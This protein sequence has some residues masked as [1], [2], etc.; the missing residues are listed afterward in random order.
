MKRRLALVLLSAVMV[1]ALAF[2][3]AACG[4]KPARNSEFEEYEKIVTTV[5]ENTVGKLGER[6]QAETQT[7]AAK[8]L[9]SR[10]FSAED[11]DEL[12]VYLNGFTDKEA[13][14]NSSFYRDV[15]EQT[16]YLP[17][18]GGDIIREYHGASNFYGVTICAPF[19]GQYFKTVSEGTRKITYAL[20]DSPQTNNAYIYMEI[21]F[22][23]ES[24]FAFRA[25]QTDKTGTETLFLYGNDDLQFLA[26]SHGG[27]DGSDYVL[28][29]NPNGTGFRILDG[30][31]IEYCHE[32][33]AEQFSLVDR[34]VL[35]GM[36]DEEYYAVAEDEWN[37][38]NLKYFP[39]SGMTVDEGPEWVIENGIVSAY[40]WEHKNMTELTLPADAEAVFFQLHIPHTVKKL[41]FPANI[42]SIK[43]PED[44]LEYLET[45][46]APEDSEPQPGEPESATVYVDCPAKYFQIFLNGEESRLEEISVEDGCDIFKVENNCL[47]GAD[48]T[49][50]YVPENENI[51]SLSFASTDY[52]RL[53][54]GTSCNLQNLK[55][56]EIDFEGDEQP[57]FDDFYFEL[58]GISSLESVTLNNIGTRNFSVTVGNV[59]EDRSKSIKELYLGGTGDAS[60]NISFC[61]SLQNVVIGDGITDYEFCAVSDSDVE[62]SLSKDVQTGH[63]SD[64]DTGSKDDPAYTETHY[65][66]LLP[67]SKI[68]FEHLKK[69]TVLERDFS[70]YVYAEHY[71][72]YDKT[73]F[74]HH[75]A[76]CTVVFQ[77]LSAAEQDEADR[78]DSFKDISFITEEYSE[79]GEPYAAI[80]GYWGEENVIKVPET[81]LGYPVYRFELRNTS[82]QTDLPEPTV[83]GVTELHLPA[84]LKDFSVYN[85]SYNGEP[86]YALEK[87]VYGGTKEEFLRIINDQ[88]YRELY[89]LLEFTEEIICNGEILTPPQQP[90][91]E[92][93][94]F[95]GEN[96]NT[97]QIDLDWSD[98]DAKSTIKAVQARLIYNGSEYISHAFDQ[99]AFSCGLQFGGEVPEGEEKDFASVNFETALRDS[100]SSRKEICNLRVYHSAGGELNFTLLSTT[101]FTGTIE[102]DFSEKDVQEPDCWSEGFTQWY[103]S[104]CGA[105]GETTD[106]KPAL[107]HDPDKYGTCSRC[108]ENQYFQFNLYEDT[109]K[110]YVALAKLTDTDLKTVYVPASYDGLPVTKIESYAFAYSSVEKVFLPENIEIIGYNAFDSCTNMKEI[111]LPGS[112]RTIEYSA[113]A[114]CPSLET[115]ILSKDIHLESGEFPGSASLYYEGTYED[116][117]NWYGERFFGTMYFFSADDPYKTGTAKDG[118]NYWRYDP[119]GVTPVIW[120]KETT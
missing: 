41:T 62:I 4:D 91:R 100:Y 14:D 88:D 107:G 116:W 54:S 65:R 79:Y 90:A 101:E 29:D 58:F 48:G 70:E 6:T 73:E 26:I 47:Y 20:T 64:M 49:L 43:I 30:E 95:E 96:G 17:L 42:K 13:A 15:F 9:V 75:N 34:A 32:M 94:L 24:D 98:Y 52:G 19:W 7:A 38:V 27:T 119:D 61:G 113:F 109:G 69:Y 23:S 117:I 12:F 5:I 22:K 40:G 80:A 97:L 25:L 11:K 66:I 93:W 85:Y 35:D 81:I 45:G 114:Y 21:D 82:P 18:I 84:A 86:Q 105:F 51:T 36:K 115:V 72:G 37:A 67:W 28:F 74:E 31:T 78:L 60:V 39:D 8:A 71:A 56:L 108:G 46:V 87:I 68:K 44:D 102:H 16:F 63:I 106:R 53:F 57:A 76:N 77:P 99:S 110:E 50:V 103:C 59:W 2:G 104:I 1:L 120:I 10:A 118:V 33:V 83:E 92:S 3:L 112:L 111:V 55:E 89:A